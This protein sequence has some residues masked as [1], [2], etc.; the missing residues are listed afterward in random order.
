MTLN[1]LEWRN[2]PYFVF[3]TEFDS[4]AGCRPI[5]SLSSSLPLLAKTNAP[6]SGLSAIAE[7]LVSGRAYNGWSTCSSWPPTLKQR[8]VGCIQ[9]TNRRFAA[10]S[11]YLLINE[12]NNNS[13]PPQTPSLVGRGTPLPMLHSLR[14]LNPRAYGTPPPPTGLCSSPDFDVVWVVRKDQGFEWPKGN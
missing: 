10:T 9:I 5:M 2:S 11:S 1:N 7:H 8:L 13:P 6:C 3:F 14:R 4:C 12:L